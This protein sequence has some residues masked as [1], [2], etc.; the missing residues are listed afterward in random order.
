MSKLKI[1]GKDRQLCMGDCHYLFS[2]P[3]FYG[4]PSENIIFITSADPFLHIQCIIFTYVYESI[5]GNPHNSVHFIGQEKEIPMEIKKNN[6]F[7]SWNVLWFTCIERALNGFLDI[8]DACTA[9][10]IINK[11]SR[12]LHLL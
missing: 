1:Y 3:G 4:T 6:V 8:Q 5:I 9:P 2:S 12:S 10:Q 11:C 7:D